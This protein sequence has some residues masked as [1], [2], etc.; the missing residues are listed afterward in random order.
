[1]RSGCAAETSSISWRS[2]PPRPRPPIANATLGLA[3]DPA[4][5]PLLQHGEVPHPVGVVFAAVEMALQQAADRPRVEVAAPEADRV[6]E[7]VF[8]P[9]P[10]LPP[11]PGADRH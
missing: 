5:V 9:G 10:Q 1:M 4:P 2:E 3:I 7:E 11:Q 8:H 6:E